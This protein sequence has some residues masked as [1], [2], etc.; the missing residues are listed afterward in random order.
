MHKVA[1]AAKAPNQGVGEREGR[2]SKIETAS[3]AE[4]AGWP[5]WFRA[6]RAVLI[7]GVLALA[8]LFY[9]AMGAQPR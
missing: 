5:A 1:P 3:S 6:W 7:A 4:L 2:M 9:G 8:A